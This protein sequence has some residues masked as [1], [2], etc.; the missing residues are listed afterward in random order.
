MDRMFIFF[1]SRDLTSGP[2]DAGLEFEDV[3]FDTSDGVSLHGWFVPGRADTALLWFHGN[4][5]NVSHRVQNI[6]MLHHRLGTG[7]FIFDYRG[8]G[9]SGGSPSEDGLYRDG[10][11]A[12]AYLEQRRGIDPKNQVALFGRSLGCAVAVEMAARHET[13]A[14]ILESPFTSIRA[15]AKRSNPLLSAI[16]PTGVVVRSKF[17]S[18]S[19]IHRVR[20]PLMVLHGDR[21]DVVPLTMG[22]ELW[23][24]ARVPKT[25]F[26]V[27][28][29][30]HDD[31]YLVGGEPYFDALARFISAPDSA[32]VK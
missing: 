22:Q 21:D 7:I 31:V 5:G 23:E 11:A 14:L 28:G 24:A 25:F 15:M 8:Y 20:A 30:G 3:L 12:I 1:P 27:E 4:A 16:L 32:D 6:L 2:A 29:A 19:K 13:R 18:L 9:R 17:D 26:T 10:E